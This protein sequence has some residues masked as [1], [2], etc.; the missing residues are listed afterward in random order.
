MKLSLNQS[1]PLCPLHILVFWQKL[2]RMNFIL[3]EIVTN[4]LT[5]FRLRVNNKPCKRGSLFNN[6]PDSTSSIQ[7]QICLLDESAGNEAS[8]Q[9]II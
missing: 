9:S 8:K 2:T 1:A 7:V 5:P 6:I 4:I 3:E